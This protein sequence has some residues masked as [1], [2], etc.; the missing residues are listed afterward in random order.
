MTLRFS[1]G[2][3]LAGAL[4]W[5]APS[6]AWVRDCSLPQARIDISR[7]DG[8]PVYISPPSD[9]ARYY[10]IEAQLAGVSGTAIVVCD[11]LGGALDCVAQKVSPAGMGFEHSARLVR[12]HDK[13]IG[14]GAIF[15]VDYTS[16]SVGDCSTPFTAAP[17]WRLQQM[18][19]R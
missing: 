8:A 2:L 7:L 10:P 4:S 14:S 18:R 9:L 6:H 12:I 3:A 13:R 11:R 15:R 5:P 16:L 17:D 19:P 1:L